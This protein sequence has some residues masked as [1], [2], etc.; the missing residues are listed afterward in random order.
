MRAAWPA[1]RSATLRVAGGVSAHGISPSRAR[2]SLEVWHV[3][4]GPR[5]RTGRPSRPRR[6]TARHR[7]I[8]PSRSPPGESA[9]RGRPAGRT[10]LLAVPTSARAGDPGRSHRGRVLR[11][12]QHRDP[13][14]VAVPSGQGDVPPRLLPH[15]GDRAGP[16]AAGLFPAGRAGEARPYRGRSD[17]DPVAFISGHT[18]AEITEIG[19]EVYEGS[20]TASGS[21]PGTRAIAQ[22]HL[23]V[24]Q[25]VRP[26]TAAPIEVVVASS[27]R[28]SA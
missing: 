25:Q 28:G 6:G 13:G 11:P 3:Y 8:P 12:G 16:L 24:G 27:R 22:L 15:P 4:R 21:G 18:V 2:S 19:H 7:C 14:G 23:D 10:P 1:T 5:D 17:R 9:G 20:I 26:A